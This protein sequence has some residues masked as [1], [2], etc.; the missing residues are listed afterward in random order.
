MADVEEHAR[1]LKAEEVGARM[2]EDAKK[3]VEEARMEEDAKKRAE[4][5]VR[6]QAGEA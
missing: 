6:T 3:R 5:E 2:E 4:E 1:N